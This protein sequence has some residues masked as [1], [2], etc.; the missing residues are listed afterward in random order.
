MMRCVNWMCGQ[1]CGSNSR[2]STNTVS[3]LSI[4][5]IAFRINFLGLVSLAA[6]GINKILV[7]KRN[8]NPRGDG[9]ER[10]RDL[11]W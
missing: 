5:A 11:T 10:I 7:Y 9:D 6:S 2:G 8:D 1:A 3:L 4:I